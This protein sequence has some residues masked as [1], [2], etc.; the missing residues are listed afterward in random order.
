MSGKGSD[1]QNQDSDSEEH[2]DCEGVETGVD[3]QQQS[4]RSPLPRS[5]VARPLIVPEQVEL[6]VRSQLNND[7]ADRVQERSLKII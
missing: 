7:D 2:L 5:S 1:D 3:R 4:S 6:V